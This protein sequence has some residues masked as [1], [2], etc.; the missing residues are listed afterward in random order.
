MFAAWTATHVSCYDDDVCLQS[1]PRLWLLTDR[2]DDKNFWLAEAPH[3]TLVMRVDQTNRQ[4][5]PE[6][7]K[8]KLCARDIAWTNNV[9]R[10][11]ISEDPERLKLRCTRLNLI[12][13]AASVSQR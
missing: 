7:R 2:I 8:E 13:G 1:I 11:V 4:V 9:V 5:S 12:E 10:V 3:A 6:T